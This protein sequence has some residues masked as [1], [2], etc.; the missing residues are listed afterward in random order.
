MSWS[1][2]LDLGDF[3]GLFRLWD[4]IVS[5]TQTGK[6]RHSEA[7]CPWM[8][9]QWAV[10]ARAVSTQPP[11]RARAGNH[12]FPTPPTFPCRGTAFGGHPWAWLGKGL[13]VLQTEPPGRRRLP[14]ACDL[15]AQAAHQ[16]GQ[17]G[18]PRGGK[19]HTAWGLRETRC[20]ARPG[21][22]SRGQRRHDVKAQAVRLA[23]H[24]SDH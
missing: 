9:R 23:E 7:T 20:R 13:V 6:L 8:Q 17:P 18:K 10:G 3:C 19:R 1:K 21:F 16:Q 24:R 4:S 12:V 5:M 22:L 11:L 14:R 15:R 2:G